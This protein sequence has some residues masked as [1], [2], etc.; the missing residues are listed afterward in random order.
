MPSRCFGSAAAVPCRLAGQERQKK[1]VLSRRGRAAT[2]I[3][4][5]CRTKPSGVRTLSV[6]P[7]ERFHRHQRFGKK[8]RALLSHARTRRPGYRVGYRERRAR[9]ADTAGH[10]G[11][12]KGGTRPFGRNGL[13]LSPEEARDEIVR[14]EGFFSLLG[15]TEEVYT[16][17]KRLVMTY[18]VIGVQVHEARLGA[19]D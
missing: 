5:L 6:T 11:F 15:E 10:A 13:G 19:A 17:W 14:M 1:R 12:P 16:E 4:R 3:S 18:K 9:C 2:R 8:Y 7:D